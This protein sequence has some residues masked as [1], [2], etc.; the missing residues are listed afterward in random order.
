M[1]ECGQLPTLPLDLPQWETEA[2]LKEL[3]R[4]KLKSDEMFHTCVIRNRAL[5]EWIEAE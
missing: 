2:A 5:V 1:L 3:L 4:T